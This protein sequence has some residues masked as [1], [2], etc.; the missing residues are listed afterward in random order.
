M[1][2]EEFNQKVRVGHYSKNYVDVKRFIDIICKYGFNNSDLPLFIASDNR[3][4]S[5][6]AVAY[7]RK[8]F[9]TLNDCNIKIYTPYKYPNLKTL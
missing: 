4:Y 6:A 3:T 9:D 5:S 8:A 1:D 7:L 2:F